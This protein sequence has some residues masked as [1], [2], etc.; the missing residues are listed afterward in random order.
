MGRVGVERKKRKS[1]YAKNPAQAEGSM[2]ISQGCRETTTTV[3]TYPP[4]QAT[5]KQTTRD[6]RYKGE[7]GGRWGLKELPFKKWVVK[8]QL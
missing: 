3:P 6:V 4:P 7:E 2:S 1:V 8:A 5:D